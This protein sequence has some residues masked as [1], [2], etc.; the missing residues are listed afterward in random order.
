MLTDEQIDQLSG[1]ETYPRIGRRR[2][3]AFQLL[4]ERLGVE[5]NPRQMQRYARR[6]DGLQKSVNEV[7][8]L[9]EVA[10]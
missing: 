7:L 9:M 5:C 4:S 1:R 3:R 8:S 6:T 2:I 10:K